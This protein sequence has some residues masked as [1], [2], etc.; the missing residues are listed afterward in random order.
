MLERVLILEQV[1]KQHLLGCF[2]IATESNCLEVLYV[3]SEADFVSW[4]YPTPLRKNQSIGLFLG[5]FNQLCFPSSAYNH[6]KGHFSW[7]QIHT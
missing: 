5:H 2:V 4:L 3:F 1:S 6:T 7:N